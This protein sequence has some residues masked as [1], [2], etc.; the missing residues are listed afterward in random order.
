MKSGSGF[1]RSGEVNLPIPNKGIALWESDA[2]KTPV[3]AGLRSIPVQF[4]LPKSRPESNGSDPHDRVN[5]MLTVNVDK[6]KNIEY[7]VPVFFD[8]DER[9]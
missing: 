7:E 2:L 9:Y 6:D 8:P 1:A 5:W 3:S 4:K